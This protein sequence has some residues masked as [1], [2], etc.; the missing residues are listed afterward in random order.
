MAD[1]TLSAIIDRV[2]AVVEASPVSLLKSKDAFTHERQP[3]ALLTDTYHLADGG[4]YT[5]VDVT[6]NAEARVDRLQILVA[7]KVTFDSTAAMEAMHATLRAIE[8]ALIADGPAH[9]YNA[10]LNGRTVTKTAGKDFL[11]GSITML[12]D[13]DYSKV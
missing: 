13:Y 1:T 10:Q 12:F 5:S 4:L 7:R 9:S 2:Q 6:S 11:I 3:N 8:R